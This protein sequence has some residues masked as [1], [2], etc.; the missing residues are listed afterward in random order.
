MGIRAQQGGHGASGTRV[1]ALP[2][3]PGPAR[4]LRSALSPAR[5]ASGAR[6]CA[7]C[8]RPSHTLGYVS[9]S[10]AARRRTATRRA[11][12]HRRRDRALRRR[13]RGARAS[14]PW[15]P[16][17]ASPRARSTT[18]SAPR[19]GLVEAVY[20]E[21]VRRHADARDR[22]QRRPATGAR[23][24]SPS[25][26]PARAST[27]RRTP[28]YRLLTSLHLEAATSRPAPRRRSP[29][30]SSAN[31]RA[32]HDRPRP[33]PGRR[34]GSIRPGL[35]AEAVGLTVNAA[36]DGFL[37]QQLEPQSEPSAAGSPSSVPSWRTSCDPVRHR[38][39]DAPSTSRSR[40][41]AELLDRVH[42]FIE[43]DVLP[44]RG[45][46]SPT[47]TTS[48]PAG[49]SSSACAT[50]PA[51]AAST[52]R[53]CPRSGAASG[54]GVL[55]M[56]LIS[57]EVGGSAAGRAGHERDGARRGQHAHAA[58]RGHR[59]SRTR[60]YLRPLAEGRTRSCFAMTEPDVASSRPDEP[61]DD[62]RARRRRVGPQRAQVVHHRRAT[63]R[64]SR[65]WWPRPAP[66]RPP[67]TATTR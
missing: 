45:A 63:A 28:F 1:V 14:T 23:G 34:D 53:T 18:T 57:Q 3:T 24:C 26:T 44:G 61:R 42:A 37:V 2:P 38:P 19:T 29:A 16:T 4:R 40:P 62:R 65:S 35:D 10:A 15:P 8:A 60:R 5:H 66:T 58:A 30:A 46:R 56:A 51:S 33:R 13:R 36:L 47:P 54:V 55:G 11:P 22:R 43:E 9:Q 31:Q 7:P 27:A 20:K 50:A 49:T 32:L 6:S 39:A 59:R 64:R 48:W 21:V 12:A 17:S 52:R 25:S 67:G 41:S